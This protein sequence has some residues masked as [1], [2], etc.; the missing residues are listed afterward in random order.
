[1]INTGHY[2]GLHRTMTDTPDTSPGLIYVAPMNV[3]ATTGRIKVPEPLYEVGILEPEG[4]IYW[5]YEETTGVLIVSN[6]ELQEDSYHTVTDT[7]IYPN[8]YVQVP[9]PFFPPS[10]EAGTV[11][12][13][14]KIEHEDAYVRR[15]QLR[16][17]IYREDMAEEE[18]K[19][20]YLLTNTEVQN[21]LEDPDDW[22]GEF[23][24]RPQFI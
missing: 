13:A 14:R 1:M 15:N 18:P 6:A 4:D 21:R 11:E 9:S 22:A 2:K 3:Q 17:F 16:H 8:D 23:G 24:S 19:S 20:C 10:H 7:A 5:A 12:A